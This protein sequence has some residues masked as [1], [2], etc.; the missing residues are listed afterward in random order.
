MLTAVIWLLI[1]LLVLG[2]VFYLAVWVL[3]LLGIAIPP[4]V[5][6]IVGAIVFLIVLLWFVQAVMSGSPVGFGRL[7]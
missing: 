2:L 5:V 4:N 6:K 7:N 1:Y 3:E